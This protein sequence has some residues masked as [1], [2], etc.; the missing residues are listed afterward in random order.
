[1]NQT[2][3]D[4]LNAKQLR[5]VNRLNAKIEAKAKVDEHNKKVIRQIVIDEHNKRMVA[6]F[7][8]QKVET[9]TRNATWNRS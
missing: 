9:S 3:I 1:M 4:N 8:N 2:L 7:N 6:F 5:A